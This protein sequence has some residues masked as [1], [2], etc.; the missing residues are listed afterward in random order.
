LGQGAAGDFN[1]P[2]G[3]LGGASEWGQYIAQNGLKTNVMPGGSC[4]SAC[5]LAWSAGSQKIIAADGSVGVHQTTYPKTDEKGASLTDAQVADL[6]KKTTDASADQL[7]KNGAP[8]DV[9]NAARTTPPSSIYWLTDADLKAWNVVIGTDVTEKLS[10]WTPPPAPTPAPSVASAPAAAPKCDIMKM[11]ATDWAICN[12]GASIEAPQQKNLDGTPIYTPAPR[13]PQF[14]DRL[15][16]I[17]ARSPTLRCTQWG[18]IVAGACL[19]HKRSAKA[20]GRAVA[21]HRA[22]TP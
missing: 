3:A 5:V 18:L 11:K 16:D 21:S 17:V 14:R 19:A 20:K 15:G 8:A 7:Q 22:A 6:T 13:P 10:F 4:A 9:V 2:G 1:S 12:A